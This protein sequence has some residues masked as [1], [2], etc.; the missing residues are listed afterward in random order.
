M[1]QKVGGRMKHKN[2]WRTCDRCGSEIKIRPISQMKF[3]R[4]GDYCTP[5][6][7]FEDEYIRGEI[8]TCKLFF[9]HRYDLCPKC[10]KEFERWIKY[11]QQ[12]SS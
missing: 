8:H 5:S 4:L 1:W 12:Y 9:E 10:R 3:T 6:P 2:E 7:I 11:D